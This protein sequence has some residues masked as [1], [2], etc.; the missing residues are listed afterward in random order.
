MYFSK[1]SINSH[2]SCIHLLSY[3]EFDPLEFTSKLTEIE[4]ERLLSF[5][6]T[7][8]R[9]EFVATRILRHQ[10]FGYQHIHYDDHG[11]PFIPNEGFISVS[12]SKNLIGIAVN[13]NYKVGLD[14]E[15][16][17]KNILDLK[18]KF[19]SNN[20]LLQFNCDDFIEVTKIWSAKEALYKL[21][22]RK[23]ILFSKELLL[24]KDLNDKWN[25]T[26]INHDHD[27]KVKM[28]IF[29]IDETIISINSAEIERI[30]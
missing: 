29:D 25:G 22:G 21:A 11:A 23:K 26:I 9:R 17:R 2:S 20:E 13:E 6:N 10:L 12:H 3:K 5:K 8:R 18:S 24:S 1:K 7:N 4:T 16:H 30:Q 14:L 15:A 28:D 27:L 19:L